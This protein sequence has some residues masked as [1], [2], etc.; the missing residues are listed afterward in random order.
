MGQVLLHLPLLPRGPYLTPAGSE[1]AQA[2][3]WGCRGG[4]AVAQT[5]SCAGGCA[6][7]GSQASLRD[8]MSPSSGPFELKG[9][10]WVWFCAQTEAWTGALHSPRS[11]T[12]YTTN[13]KGLENQKE[14]LKYLIF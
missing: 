6:Y 1:H 10:S 3:G 11:G 14:R 5:W 9:I 7:T 13:Q 4:L 2:W 8:Q 12:A